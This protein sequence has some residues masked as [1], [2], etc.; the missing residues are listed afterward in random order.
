[1]IE[2]DNLKFQRASFTTAATHLSLPLWATVV[3][4][5]YSLLLVTQFVLM[6]CFLSRLSLTKRDVDPE[7]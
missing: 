4:I 1:M 5:L 2:P 6:L 3:A 7:K